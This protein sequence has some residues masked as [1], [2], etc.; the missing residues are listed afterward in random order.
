[1][2]KQEEGKPERG[3][4]IFVGVFIAVVLALG[5]VVYVSG[6]QLGLW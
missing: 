3:G 4:A 2:N 1:M 6:A 5:F